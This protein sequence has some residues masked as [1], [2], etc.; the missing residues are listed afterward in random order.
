MDYKHGSYIEEQQTRIVTPAIAQAAM[1]VVVGVAPVHN[2][3]ANSKIPV[4]EPKLVYNLPEFEKI[5][6]K[7]GPQD[8]QEDYK[9]WQNAR[10][11]FERYSV[12]PLVA[13]NVFDP[14]KHYR[15]VGGDD[16]YTSVSP[17][18]SIGEGE[19]T[20]PEEVPD[21]KAVSVD[22]ILGENSK[23]GIRSGLTLVEEILPRF[24][25]N[26]GLIMAPG[27]SKIPAVAKAIETA[28]MNIGGFFRSLGIIEIADEAATFADAPAWLNDNNLCDKDGNTIA[29]FGDC[30]FNEKIEPGAAHLAGCIGARDN[31]EGGIPYW[32]PSNFQLEC[33]CLVHA[34][35][36]L[37][38]TANEA[39]Y[40][41]GQGIVTGLNMLGGLRCWGD[42]TTAYPGVTDP[43]DN[44]IP[45]RRMFTWIENTLIMT[46]WQFV[47]SPIRRRLI[48]TVQDTINYWLNGLV[49]RD[50]ILGGRCAFE[51]ADN[52]TLDLMDGIVRWHVYI[53]PPAAARELTFVVEYDPSN[54][55]ALFQTAGA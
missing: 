39:N 16:G 49:A 12:A 3:P 30:L 31:Q 20:L 55:S 18:G 11:Y 48:E 53:T 19:V 36:K 42:Q 23:A 32:S 35:R 43:K 4:N 38:L 27:F 40:L 9:L 46:S 21:P 29:F 6:G 26:P 15:E 51:G 52:P 54:L 7:P 1:P 28:C 22:D 37:Y 34:G 10:V 44:S 5:F 2:L 45:I 50:F 8:N 41:N 33:E 13:I 25:L 17:D 24:R 14:Q 47:S